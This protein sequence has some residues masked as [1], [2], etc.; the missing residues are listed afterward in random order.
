MADVPT[1]SD[2]HTPE[3]VQIESA[4][5]LPA[6]LAATALMGMVLFISFGFAGYLIFQKRGDL[7]VRSLRGT[8]ATELEQSRL[9]PQTKQAVIERLNRLADDI[10]NHLRL[11]S[12][13]SGTI[14]SVWRRR[15][16]LG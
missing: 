2:S 1:E 15:I 9:D 4:G 6:I 3:Q 5:C 8:L 13:A 7:A 12:T 14:S 16:S 11:V 10:E